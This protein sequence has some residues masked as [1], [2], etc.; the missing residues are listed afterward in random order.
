MADTRAVEVALRL[1]RYLSVK[2]I[3]TKVSTSYPKQGESV[4]SSWFRG[5]CTIHPRLCAHKPAG[6]SHR[7]VDDI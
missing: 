1:D 3:L 2:G 7:T 5:I 4:T 6:Q